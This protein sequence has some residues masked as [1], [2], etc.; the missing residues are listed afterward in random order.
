MQQPS[1]NL[2]KETVGKRFGQMFTDY[3]LPELPTGL[4]SAEQLNFLQDQSES[5][6]SDL[7]ALENLL[8]QNVNKSKVLR[9]GNAPTG[10]NLITVRIP[11]Q[12]SACMLTFAYYKEAWRVHTI[13][14]LQTRRAE[15]GKLVLGGL[16]GA[17]A[18]ALF[19]LILSGF[20][21]GDIVAQAKEEGYV[22]LTQEQYAEQTGQS[23]VDIA[24]K[25]KAANQGADAGDAKQPAKEDASKGEA[26]TFSL[27]EGMTTWDLTEFLKEQGL[28]QDRM[29]FSTKL[30]EL[31][32]D[33]M[34]R[35]QDYH[36]T[37]GMTEAEVIEALK[38]EV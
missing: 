36:F 3:G 17:A 34:L 1:F 18:T 27:K 29:Q 4:F 24:A 5:L 30:T 19:A 13:D 22:V 9:I 11:L 35:P 38:K 37:K 16:V 8:L 10:E 32:L 12:K 21:G 26:I 6:P 14:A 7:G 2:L 33:T 25:D 15:I 23:Q 20:S 28:I 31:G